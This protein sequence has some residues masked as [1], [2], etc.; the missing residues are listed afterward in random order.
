[1]T[2]ENNEPNYVTFE[3]AF[4]ALKQGKRIGRSEWGGEEGLFLYLVG[5]TNFEVNSAPLNE[6]FPEGTDVNYSAH[7]DIASP[8]GNCGVW[9]PSI[10]DMMQDDW[11][12]MEN[13]MAK[14][15][16]R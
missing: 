16:P 4:K 8:T 15:E 14:V 3:E 10:Y 2:T 11:V 9:T 6:F 7:V 1:M 5:E 13:K 12:I